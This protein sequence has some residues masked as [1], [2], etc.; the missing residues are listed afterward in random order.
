MY[1]FFY[2]YRETVANVCSIQKY[3]RQYEKTMNYQQKKYDEEDRNERVVQWKVNNQQRKANSAK[4]FNQM[5]KRANEQAK[6]VQQEE[7]QEKSLCRESSISRMDS[8]SS[9]QVKIP[10]ALEAKVKT[11]K[12]LMFCLICMVL[13]P[14]FLFNYCYYYCCEFYDDYSTVVI[15]AIMVIMVIMVIRNM[16]FY[17]ICCRASEYQQA[18]KNIKDYYE[19]TLSNRINTYTRSR[20]EAMIKAL[21]GPNAAVSVTE[22]Q[23]SQYFQEPNLSR[24]T[25]LLLP[26]LP[27]LTII[28]DPLFV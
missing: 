28:F 23:G 27:S 10:E 25:S 11:A 5:I 15:V 24:A 4:Q 12:R 13:I 19:K 14:F 1:P 9:T 22:I 7:L 8:M 17:P 26:K 6:R 20:S 2:S 18:Q 16:F 3:A 21:S